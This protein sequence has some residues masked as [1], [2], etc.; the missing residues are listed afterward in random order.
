MKER[1]FEFDM[2]VTSSKGVMP[3]TAEIIG[4]SPLPNGQREFK[5]P[6]FM[7]FDAGTVITVQIRVESGAVKLVD[8]RI[9]QGDSRPIDVTDEWK[10]VGTEYFSPDEYELFSTA[11]LIAKERG[12]FRMMLVGAPGYGKTSRPKAWAAAQDMEYVRVDCSSVRDPEEFFIY[13]TAKDGNTI[14]VQTR[15]AESLQRGKSVIVL[16]E[17]NR[18]EPYL[19]N[20][21]L[22]ILDF[23]GATDIRNQHIQNGPN[24]LIVATMNQG[25]QF[26]GTFAPDMALSRRY[27]A[28]LEIKAPPIDIEIKILEDKLEVEHEEASKIVHLLHRLRQRNNSELQIATDCALKLGGLVKAGMRLRRAA[29]FV[30]LNR[31]PNDLL[32][33]VTDLVNSEIGV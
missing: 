16:D 28:W 31:T 6:V 14:D 20:P 30:I 9:K 11:S 8:T 24:L 3:G 17:L 26:T 33:E 32:K 12:I 2:R 27:D 13:R 19:S 5:Y 15:F 18:L 10:K 29:Q 22:P 21:L 4:E 23:E 1:I 7:Q 25:Y